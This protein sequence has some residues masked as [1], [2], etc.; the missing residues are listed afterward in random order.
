MGGL[1]PDESAHI[2]QPAKQTRL[3][4]IRGTVIGGILLIVTMSCLVVGAV[5]IVHWIFK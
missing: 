3:Q 2:Y 1:E 4:E 5:T